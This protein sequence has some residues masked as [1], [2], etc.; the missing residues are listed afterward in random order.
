[1][2]LA[3]GAERALLVECD[4]LLDPWNVARL[5]QAVVLREKPDLVIMGKQAVDDDLNQTGQMLAALLDWPQAT[6][7]SKLE[8]VESGVRVERETDLGIETVRVSLPAVITTDLRLNEPRYASIPSIMKAR[9][10]TIE[11]VAY[12]EYGVTIEARIQI[13]K[14][15]VESTLR[16]CVRVKD[17]D[18]LLDRL[19]NEAKVI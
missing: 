11:R 9:K 19:R 8:F 6:F 2:A 4:L 13:L 17:V 10:K 1:M 3:M 16:S 14:V 15:E 12:T 18:D 5:F 7:A